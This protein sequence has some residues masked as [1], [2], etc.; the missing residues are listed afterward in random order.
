MFNEIVTT[1]IAL[2]FIKKQDDKTLNYTKLLKLLYLVDRNLL[3]KHGYRST[4]DEY[5]NMRNG[6]VLSET[7]DLIKGSYHNSIIW[8][9]CI[10]TEGMDVYLIEEPDFPIDLDPNVKT[11]IEELNEKYHDVHYGVLIDFHHSLAEWHN[12][13]WS[14][15][16]FKEIIDNLSISEPDKRKINMLEKANKTSYSDII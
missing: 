11:I 16:D 8:Q 3:E 9:E 14:P 13:H 2:E 4:Y 6:V 5:I 7:Y 12:T 10:G 1:Q 15:T